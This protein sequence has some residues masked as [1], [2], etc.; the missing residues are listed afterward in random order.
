MKC[1][2]CQFENRDQARFC[3]QC[4]TKLE[5]TCPQ[6]NRAILPEA[7]FC[8]QCGFDLA[9]SLQP[10]PVD[11][12]QPR[13][14]TPQFLAQ[15]II[16]HRGV[17]EGE[18]KLVTV[19]FAD[20]VN[21][22]SIS[23]NLDPED[24]H[25]LMD[26]CFRLLMDEIHRYEGTIIQ[27]TG[28]GVM[29]L[30]GAPIAHED[31]ARR[32]CHAALAIQETMKLFGAEV[33]AEWHVDF[34][35]RVGLNSGLVIVGS[36]GDD[37][38]MDYTALGDTT[39]LASRMESMAPAGS[40]LV[41]KDTHKLAQHFFRFKAVGSLKVKGKGQPVD[42]YELIGAGPVDTRF[43][44][45]AVRG[46]T[47]FVGRDKELETLRQAFEKVDAGSGQVIGLVGEAGVGKSRLIFELRNMLVDRPHAFLQGHCLHFGS[48]MAYLPILDV[49]K[50]YF[51]V[52]DHVKETTIKRQIL[53]CIKSLD[54]KLVYI[55]PPIQELLSLTVDDESYLRLEPR[56]R[57]E[58][59]FEALRDLLIR[60]SEERPVILVIE[61]LHWVDK[62]SED[63]LTYLIGWLANTRILLVILY[64]PDYTH[65]WANRSYYLRL[66][67]DEL[68]AQAR[69][70]L[71]ALLLPGAP[72][73]AGLRD[74]IISRA[75]GNPLFME[76]LTYA[77]TEK[78]YITRGADGYTLAK[79]VAEVQVPDTVQGII[80]AR[81]DRLEENLKRTMQISS[82][83]GRTFSFSILDAITA[84]QEHLK[85]YL[86]ELQGCEFIY[87][88]SLFPELKYIFKHALVQE[89]AYN[90]L[91]LKRRKEIH[92][93]IGQAIES[94]YGERLEEFYEMLAYHYARSEHAERAYAYLKLSG[95]KATKNSAPWEAFRFYRDAINVLSGEPASDTTIK[96]QVEIRL[97]MVSPMISIGFPEDSLDILQQGEKLCRERGDTKCLTTL[98]SMIGLYHSVKGNPLLGVRYN[99]DCLKIAEKEQALDLMAPVAFD[100]CSNYAARGE[101]LKIVDVAPR[102]L[103]LLE[104]AGKQSECFDRGYNVYSALSM[105]YAF[106]TGYTGEFSK[107]NEIFQ[108]GIAAAQQIENLYSLGL[109]ETLHGYLFC[110]RGDG[111]EALS[112]FTR[113]IHYLEKGQIFVLLGL[114]WSGVGWSHYFMGEPATGLPFI[115][116]GLKIHSD[117]GIS[118]DLSVHYYFL[119]VVHT[120]LG[121][122]ELAHTYIQQALKLAQKY[123]EIYYVGLSLPALG[124]ILARW[125]KASLKEAEDNVLRGINLLN[126]LM[127][128]PQVGIAYLCLAE[129]YAQYQQAQKAIKSLKTAESIFRETGMEYWLGRTQQYQKI[130]GA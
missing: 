47:K 80:A 32:A 92:G 91:L 79:Q 42:A 29:A 66:G 60:L 33:A 25:R 86:Q 107:A 9:T 34:S 84:G 52:T 95:I 68:P 62:T 6:C 103:A 12:A 114:A 38:R 124:R 11:Y 73:T 118:Y 39:N 82:V 58:R 72:V 20:V 78:E 81:I 123:N 128:K 45:A 126:D 14:Y 99:E 109:G 127:V 116:K 7:R 108:K 77:L 65:P 46:F 2:T 28:D 3:L 100:L 120:E 115:E 89:V 117:A 85:R 22:T 35:M 49:I 17:V 51:S 44:A 87:E 15:K 130:L 16:N 76:E 67:L 98:L 96:E 90:S 8:D 69:Q 40:I 75:G 112:H 111:K 41:S 88:E 94:L 104:R 37:L 27:F 55:L 122:L 53:E 50:S 110:H 36:I 43:A 21:Y 10:P 113:G 105:F 26:R 121:N 24:V 64:R 18:R 74:F 59:T 119:A 54:E 19:L 1:P 56:H 31:H 4:G 101:F 106:A 23:E 30:F 13:S 93:K 61:D 5:N 71:L 48:S 83:I 125:G 97:L 70:E 57:R 102:I 63:F 129:V